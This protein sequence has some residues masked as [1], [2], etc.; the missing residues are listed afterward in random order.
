MCGQV[1]VWAW[2]IISK[3]STYLDIQPDVSDMKQF[4]LKLTL[5]SGLCVLIIS[6]TPDHC[7]NQN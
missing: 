6:K 2:I 7:H 4:L 3:F 5:H 1:T